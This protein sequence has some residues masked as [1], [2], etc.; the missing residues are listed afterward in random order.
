MRIVRIAADD[1]DVG[2]AADSRILGG[3][4]TAGDAADATAAIYD[5]LTVTGTD[6]FSIKAVQKT[7]SPCIEFETP[8]LFRT[9][10]S[11]DMTGAGAVLHLF[12]E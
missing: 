8:V 7:T 11:V 2:L 3:F 6:I 9:G 4:L 10:V 5:A 1:N 12:V